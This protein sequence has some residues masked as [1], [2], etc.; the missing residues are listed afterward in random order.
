MAE[1]F[2]EFLV[3]KKPLK[4][5]RLCG[6]LV[7]GLDDLQTCE[8]GENNTKHGDNN[9]HPST[10]NCHFLEFALFLFLHRKHHL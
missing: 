2:T 1:P 9:H 6:H 4:N 5:Q 7:I 3:I 10:N 8:R